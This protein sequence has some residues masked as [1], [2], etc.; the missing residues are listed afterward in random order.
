MFLWRQLL[1]FR[2]VFSI[3]GAE[4]SEAT[5]ANWAWTRLRNRLT[6]TC[7]CFLVASQTRLCS[8]LI[9]RW[10]N[11]PNF[12]PMRWKCKQECMMGA[13]YAWVYTWRASDVCGAASEARAG[14][15]NVLKHFL[16]E[17]FFCRGWMCVL[18]CVIKERKLVFGQWKRETMGQW[19][20]YITPYYSANHFSTLPNKTILHTHTKYY[21]YNVNRCVKCTT[22]AIIGVSNDG[23]F[24]QAL[25][26]LVKSSRWTSVLIHIL[27]RLEKVHSYLVW[28]W[29][30]NKEKVQSFCISPP[31]E[32]GSM[33]L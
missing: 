32:S 14:W 29:R 24:A 8:F 4:T 16:G 3:F 9:R 11:L 1:A 6:L 7:W 2:S 31:H 13:F 21:F 15:Q 12:C 25:V 5:A 27:I 18:Q 20:C 26:T 22:V 19:V 10:S 33:C 23:C 17:L 28:R 30:V